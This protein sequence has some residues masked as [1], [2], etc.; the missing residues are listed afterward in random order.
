[1]HS[2]AITKHGITKK[3]ALKDW[4][5]QEIYLEKSTVKR[6]LLI[7]DLKLFRSY[8]KGKHSIGKTFQS[9]SVPGK[10]LLT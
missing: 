1:M 4:S 6:Y 2:T 10:E 3:E 5:I 9:L 7:L 8:V